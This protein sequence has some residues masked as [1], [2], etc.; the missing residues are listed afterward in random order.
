[1]DRHRR[2][3]HA[4]TYTH[5]QPAYLEDYNA[6]VGLYLWFGLLGMMSVP[7]IANFVSK[8]Q[9]HRRRR[10]AGFNVHSKRPPQ[11]RLHRPEERCVSLR[12]VKD[13]RMAEHGTVLTGNPGSSQALPV[14][15][16][17]ATASGVLRWVTSVSSLGED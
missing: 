16:G 8:I 2:S 4:Q 11:M 5:D 7:T 13:P 6:Y 10:R 3:T 9:G 1:M 14:R 15:Y 17:D 12:R